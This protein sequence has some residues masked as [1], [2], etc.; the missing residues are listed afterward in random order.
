[1]R[2]FG[3]DQIKI[4][5]AQYLAIRQFLKALDGDFQASQW[6]T[7]RVDGKLSL[8]TKIFYDQD[9]KEDDENI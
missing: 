4:T 1:M 3:P 9:N 2:A 6:I 8:P 5:A 7:D